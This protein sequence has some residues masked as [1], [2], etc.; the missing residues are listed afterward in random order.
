MKRW[1]SFLVVTCAAWGAEYRAGSAKVDITPKELIWL[2]GYASRNKPAEGTLQPLYAKALA[3]QDKK[4]ARVVMVTTDL[5]GLSRTITEAVAA[6]LAK[7]HGIERGRVVFNSS[8][9]HTGPVIRANLTTMYTL[10]PEMDGKVAAYTRQLTDNLFTVA[11]GALGQM[12]PANLKYVEG[13]AGFAINRREAAAGGV[14]IGTNPKGPVDHTVPVLVVSG[15][16]GKPMA[17]LFGY[18]CHNT[19]LTGEHYKYSGDYA[20]FAQAEL[21]EA[22]GATALFMILCG[23]DQ[24]PNPRS[25]EKL[26]RD[27][28]H[29]LAEGVKTAMGKPGTAVKGN[30]RGAFQSIKLNFKPHTREDFEKEAQ[31]TDRFRVNRAKAML[32]AYDEGAPVRTT[33]YPVQAMRIGNAMTLVALGGEVVVDYSI[34]IKREYPREKFFV[35]GYSNDVMSYIPS[36]RILREGGYEADSSMIYYGQ[37]GPYSEDVEESIM[38]S[39]KAVLKRVGVK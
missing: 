7:E 28:G 2:S 24:N 3:I 23:A 18:A 35:A 27:H 1:L 11:A 6:R 20:G 9:T 14:K 31:S 30:V 22:T 37:P 25:S 5:I 21:E 12:K 15:E 29:E 36:V 26:A 4:G 17:I 38:G 10:S 33:P 16:D 34:R 39:V 13:T 19:T 32:K 8:H